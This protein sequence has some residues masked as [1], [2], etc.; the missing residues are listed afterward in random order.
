MRR[1]QVAIHELLGHGSGKLLRQ[2]PDGS[3]NFDADKVMSPYTGAKVAT[4]YL[5]GETWDAKFGQV[6]APA[7]APRRP[8]WLQRS[9]ERPKQSPDWLQWRPSPPAPPVAAVTR[10]ALPRSRP[11]TRSAARSAWGPPQRPAP[12]LP[13]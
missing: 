4:F 6:P 1:R 2:E 13:Y 8:E 3:F 9:P 12:A 7:P 10:R 11:P 5:P